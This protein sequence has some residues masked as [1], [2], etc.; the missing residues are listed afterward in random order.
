MKGEFKAYLKSKGYASN[1]ITTHMATI[2][3]YLDWLKRENLEATVISY[4]DLLLYMKHCQRKGRSQKTIQHYM[5]VVKLFYARLLQEQKVAINPATDIEVKGI[6]R[7][8]VYKI[9]EPHQLNEIFN[10]YE[11][12]SPAGR[13]NKV[14]LGL[15][16]YQGI[17]TEELAKLEVKNVKLREGKI[18]IPG[19]RKSNHRL[20]SLESH[21]VMDMYDY[22]LNVRQELLNEPLKGRAKASPL[23][24]ET[25]K[26]FI[27]SGGNSSSFGN[28]TSQLMKAL[29]AKYPDLQN[30]KQIRA[31]VIVKW[32]KMYNLREV[33]VMA[34]HK[35]ISTTEGYRQ[36]DMEGLKEEVNQFHPFG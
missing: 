4:N 36:N 21:Q 14:M 10:S 29:K 31:S 22:V 20:M 13:R 7:K 30:A 35:F 11:P 26:L 24:G 34:G 18:E 25:K 12:E 17:K 32:L 28:Y 8:V 5:G 33:Q 1:T 19:S 3:I 27:G 16:I 6:K 15:L 23:P 9:Y 2:G